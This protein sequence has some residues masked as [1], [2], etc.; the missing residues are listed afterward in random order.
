MEINP[1]TSFSDI[2]DEQEISF[3]PMELVDENLG[4]IKYLL[5]KKAKE[6]I[7][8][9]KF[10]E[11]DLLWAKITPCMQN[12][13]SAIAYNLIN[14]LGCGSTEFFILR[15]KSS[16]I[17]IEYVHFL[18]RDKRILK[19]AEN[20]MGGAAG[21]QRVSKDFLYSLTIP[22]PPKNIQQRIVNIMKQ[23]YD[24]KKQKEN[25]SADLLNNI[26]NYLLTALG[27][28]LPTNADDTLAERIFYVRYSFVLGGRFDPR[29]YSKKHRQILSAIE[30]ASYNKKILKDIVL[31]DTSGDWGIDDSAE[32]ND[33]ISCLTIRGTEFDNKFNLNLDNNRS[34]FRKYSTATFE[35]IQ[36]IENDILVEK[37]GGSEDQPVG[38]VALVEKDM[39]N[40]YRLAFSNFI[41]RIRIDSQQAIPE[42]VFEYLRLMHNIKVTEVMQ[43]QTNGIRNLILQEYFNQTILLPKLSEQKEI[44]MHAAQMRKR[45]YEL[46]IEAEQIVLDAKINVE[47]ILS[48]DEQ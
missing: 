23:A 2:D 7:G 17:L 11:G 24:Q 27:I 19:F 38:R 37:S 41:H 6:R 39:L 3:V 13:K 30:S 4:T 1:Q 34:K 5:T 15:P 43:T 16:E 21:Q 25:E 33:L 9:T 18:L 32:G 40:N 47:K 46:R 8:F 28:I 44:A 22:L 10:Q 29:K 45:A 31:Q 35:K 42:Y 36:L 12:G 26:N 20:F 14:G 48:G